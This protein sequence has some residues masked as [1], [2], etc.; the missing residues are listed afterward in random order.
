MKLRRYEKNPILEPVKEND[1]ESRAVFNCAAVH[2]GELFHLLYRAMGKDD[3]S[4]IGYAVSTDGFN[5]LRLDKPVFEPKNEFEALGCED[6]RIARI[7]NQFYML[8]TA[9]SKA[10]TRVSLASSENFLTWRRYGVILPDV[11]NKDAVLFPEK[12]Q[13]RFVMLHRIPPDIW[14]AYSDDLR[15]WYDHGVVMTPREKSWDCWRIGAAGPPFK[16]EEGWLLIYHGIDDHKVY[17]LGVAVFSP[18][19]P[20]MLLKRQDEPILEP[21]EDWE[22]HGDVPNVVFSCGA[23]ETEDSYYVYYGGADTAIG[24]ATV[25]KHQALD[26]S[27]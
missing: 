2:S 5:F 8:Y 15:H 22:L 19:D 10:G 27:P 16:T 21:E 14:I 25:E 12:M 7:G 4:R 3:I 26:F 6:P 9:Y 11:D 17:R 23:V 24:I 18:E 1:W 20:S 13:G